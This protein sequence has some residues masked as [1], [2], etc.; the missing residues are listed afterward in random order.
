MIQHELY[1]ARFA[2]ASSKCANGASN[3]CSGTRA[4]R[5][6]GEAQ[7]E[8]APRQGERIKHTQRFIEKVDRGNNRPQARANNVMANAVNFTGTAEQTRE[9]NPF[10]QPGARTPCIT[11]ATQHLLRE[12]PRQRA[13]K[14]ASSIEQLRGKLIDTH[15]HTL[16]H[17]HTHTHTHTDTDTH[18]H[19]QT[20]T[21]THTHTDTQTQTQ[22]QTDT[23][24]SDAASKN[25]ATTQTL[26]RP[27][28]HQS[29]AP[30]AFA[31]SSSDSNVFKNDV[32]KKCV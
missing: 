32:S 28:S 13:K 20:R 10:M 18:T 9:H 29:T 23:H 6:R 31:W 1:R 17:I 3:E 7:Q 21:H 12:R 24:K 25:K 26:L 16:T 22:T 19:T 11:P 2:P 4:L 5:Q 30:S 15:T 8:L 14:N 27:L